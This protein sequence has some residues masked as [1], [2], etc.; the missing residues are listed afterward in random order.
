MMHVTPPPT[1]D[2][3]TQELGHLRRH[4]DRSLPIAARARAF[5]AGAVLARD[6][7]AADQVQAD[8]RNLARETGLTAD[9]PFGA[10][11]V[12]HLIRSAFRDLNPFG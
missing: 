12:D 9:L 5:W 2:L 10:E 1:V 4:L 11:T 7:G 6:Y 3:L 8:L